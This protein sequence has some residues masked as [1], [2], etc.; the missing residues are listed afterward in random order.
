[1]ARGPLDAELSARLA[2]A[3]HAHAHDWRGV[4]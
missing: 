4:I 3:W 1:V 2:S